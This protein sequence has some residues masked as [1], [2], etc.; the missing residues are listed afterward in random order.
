MNADR[1]AAT[2]RMHLEMA[3]IANTLVVDTVVEWCRL[4][5]EEEMWVQR[6]MF[7]GGNMELEHGKWE[8]VWLSSG[9]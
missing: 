9:R 8:Q 6:S 7:T 1:T 2:G 4:E 3:D 5:L